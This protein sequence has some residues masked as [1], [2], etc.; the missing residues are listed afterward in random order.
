[1]NCTASPR[2]PLRRPSPVVR[3]LVNL[4][5]L[6]VTVSWA[7]A[8]AASPTFPEALAE[9]AGMGSCT[10]GCSVCHQDNNGGQGTA[11]KKFATSMLVG[12]L[13]PMNPGTVKIAVE[14]LRG[15]NKDTDGDMK[16][17]IAELAA[18]QDPNFPGGTS[19]CIPTY[20][21]GARIA[22]APAHAAGVAGLLTAFGLALLGRRARARSRSRT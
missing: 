8:A 1:M 5:L 21:C 3:A 17:D 20:G 4:S 22:P 12:G 9:A 6:A 19:I 15:S 10:P 18:G 11:S 13:L 14:S 16:S 2:H 7:G